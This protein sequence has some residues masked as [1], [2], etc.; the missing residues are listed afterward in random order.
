[1]GSN[2]LSTGNNKQGHP[3]LDKTEPL[4]TVEE[5]AAYLR[6]KPETIR[7]MARRG[8]VPAV[9]IGKVWRFRAKDIK[10]ELAT[11]SQVVV[12]MK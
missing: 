3:H 11:L 6:L 1:M 10:I 9:K 7:M 2:T 12:Y 5:V 8:K 4:W